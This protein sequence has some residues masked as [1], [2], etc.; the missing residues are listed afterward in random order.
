[1]SHDTSGLTVSYDEAQMIEKKASSQLIQ[2]KKLILVVDLDQTVIQAA[3]NQRIGEVKND[4]SDANY[5]LIK[6]VASFELQEEYFIPATDS[7][8]ARRQTTTVVYYVKIRPGLQQFLQ[9]MHQLYEMHVY[10]MATRSYAVAIAGIIDPEG[11]YF[12]DRILSRDESGSIYQKS[13]KRLFPVSTAMVAIIDDRGDVWEW[14]P[15]LIKVIPYNFFRIGDINAPPPMPQQSQNN[16]VEILDE[17]LDPSILTSS[18]KPDETPAQKFHDAENEPQVTEPEPVQSSE[19]SSDTKLENSDAVLTAEPVAGDSDMLTIKESKKPENNVPNSAPDGQNDDNEVSM[20]DIID[21][22]FSNSYP[23]TKSEDSTTLVD[24]TSNGVI[25]GNSDK[26]SENY[27]SRNTSEDTN[28]STNVSN[29]SNDINNDTNNDAASNNPPSLIGPILQD[30]DEELNNVELALKKLH[31]R[32]YKDFDKIALKRGGVQ[33]I[34]ESDLSSVGNILPKMKRAVFDDCVIL[35]SGYIDYGTP[36]DKADIVQ[37]VRSFGAI[38]VAEMIGTVTHVVSKSNS[39]AKARKAFR[40]PKVKVVSIDWIYKCIATWEKVPVTDYLLQ[41]PSGDDVEMEEESPRNTANNANDV[42]DVDTEAFVKSLN[43][44]KIDWN[45]IDEEWREFMESSGEDGEENKDDDDEEED[46]EDDDDED[47][48]DEDDDDEE[49]DDEDED[50]DEEEE[51]EEEEVDATKNTN[52]TATAE[53]SSVGAKRLPENPSA[54]SKRLP[55]GKSNNH[56]T[57]EEAATKRERSPGNEPPN[58]D[59]S[60]SKRQKLSDSEENDDEDYDEDA[61]AAELELDLI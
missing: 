43:A 10:T 42:E 54:G 60:P 38:V 26:N 46:D 48:D 57:L 9:N 17:S 8:P 40:N 13:L 45:E 44:G 5:Q 12:G 15:N 3:I 55:N 21:E 59:E 16:L 37:W 23:T 30:H 52:P 50:D 27:T 25:G 53:A 47:D 19:E 7:E 22:P 32:Y 18:S 41:T 2:R 56:E 35:F 33:N 51:E 24:L 58:S 34:R 29:D 4:P 11:K 14:S 49:E 6:E 1:M 61:L 39:T 28:T 20:V 36:F 31:S